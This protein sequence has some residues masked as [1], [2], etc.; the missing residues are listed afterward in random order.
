MIRGSD[1]LGGSILAVP[2][3][4]KPPHL[5]SCG[6]LRVIVRVSVNHAR[7]EF[8]VARVTP[9]SKPQTP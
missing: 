9:H 4:T 5:L 3:Y 1:Y 6:S 2:N 7:L 8:R